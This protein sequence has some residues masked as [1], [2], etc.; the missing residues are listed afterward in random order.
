MRERRLRYRGGGGAFFLLRDCWVADLKFGNYG[1]YGAARL[2]RR[3][4]HEEEAGKERASEGWRFLAGWQP[5]LPR[6]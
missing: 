4:L 3:A 2:G 1:N 5:E 6:R